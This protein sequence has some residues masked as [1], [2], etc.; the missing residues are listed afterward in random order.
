MK[1]LP[2]KNSVT[3]QVLRLMLDGRA[4]TKLQITDELNLHPA[5]EVT[6][7]LRDFRK[8][9]EERGGFGIHITCTPHTEHGQRMDVYRV[10]WA[11][12]WIH[13]ALKAEL[14]EEREVAA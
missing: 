5:K 10:A 2:S 6:A 12:R 3:G 14:A 11:P 7:R 13:E 1:T 8:P 9:E 4:R